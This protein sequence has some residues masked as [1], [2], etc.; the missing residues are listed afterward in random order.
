MD[1]SVRLSPESGVRLNLMPQHT[2]KNFRVLVAEWARVMNRSSAKVPGT[3]Y[4]CPGRVVV[5]EAPS[6]AAFLS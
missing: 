4:W 1:V 3:P 5:T 2:L 6:Q